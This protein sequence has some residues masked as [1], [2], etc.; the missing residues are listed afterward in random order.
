M[1]RTKHGLLAI[2][3]MTLAACA[4]PPVDQPPSLPTPSS[5]TPESGSGEATTAD[6]RREVLDKSLDDSLGEFDKTLED[7]F[8]NW[9]AIYHQ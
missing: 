1:M 5:P 4:T 9:F 7:S 8:Q 3:A 2:V 6:E